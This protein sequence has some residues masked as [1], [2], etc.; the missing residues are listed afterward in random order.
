MVS[1]L[2]DKCCIFC[3]NVRNITK[4][5]EQEL[6]FGIFDNERSWHSQ[7]KDSAYIFVGKQHFCIISQFYEFIHFLCFCFIFY[8]PLSQRQF[9]A[10]HLKN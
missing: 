5:N 2:D 1:N 10:L 8:D 3:R 9:D 7:Y 4:L 6:K